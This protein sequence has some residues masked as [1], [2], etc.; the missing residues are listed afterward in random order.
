MYCISKKKIPDVKNKK[1]V[2]KE[3][4]NIIGRCLKYKG[5]DRI[6]IGKIKEIYDGL[7][8]KD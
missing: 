3:I 4:T 8:N 1:S 5:E 6:T 2:P 7:M